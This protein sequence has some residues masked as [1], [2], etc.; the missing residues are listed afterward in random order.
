MTTALGLDVGTPCSFATITVG[1]YG[2]EVSGDEDD[3]SPD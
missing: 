1:D 3:G 2:R